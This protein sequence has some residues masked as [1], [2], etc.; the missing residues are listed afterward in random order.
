MLTAQL[1]C[2]QGLR[3]I[4]LQVMQNEMSLRNNK[5]GLRS[6]AYTRMLP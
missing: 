2:C 1:L 4:L 6:A 5:G 3:E